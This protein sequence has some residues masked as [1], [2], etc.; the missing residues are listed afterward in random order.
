MV[1]LFTNEEY[2]AVRDKLT[3]AGEA[4]QAMYH[5]VI[6]NLHELDKLKK[7]DDDLSRELMS[8]KKKP[9]VR[10]FAILSSVLFCPSQ[11]L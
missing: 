3:K 1:S 9:K 7:L 10:V 11:S 5:K 6:E 8:M 2:R 4:Y